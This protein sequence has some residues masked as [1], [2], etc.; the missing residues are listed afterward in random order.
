M[1]NPTGEVRAYKIDQRTRIIRLYL[2]LPSPSIATGRASPIHSP[3]AS[4]EVDNSDSP[5]SPPT[6]R[7]ARRCFISTVP[8]NDHGGPR[9]IADRN[10]T[11]VEFARETSREILLLETIFAFQPSIDHLWKFYLRSM[12]NSNTVNLPYFSPSFSRSK[13]FESALS[14]SLSLSLTGY[15][16]AINEV[17]KIMCV[18]YLRCDACKKL[19]NIIRFPRV[20]VDPSA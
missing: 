3:F 17:L 14:L 20:N 11:F 8:F 15:F 10:A 16:S 4:Y 1:D 19:N 12:D 13:S 18:S 2:L 6:P 9:P 5:R 7:L